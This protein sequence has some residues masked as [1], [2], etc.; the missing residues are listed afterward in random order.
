MNKPSHLSAAL[1]A[2]AALTLLVNAVNVRRI[3][4]PHDGR[5]SFTLQCKTG[6]HSIAIEYSSR[7]AE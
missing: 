7:Q 1:L 3:R 6:S 5:T 2:F 4:T